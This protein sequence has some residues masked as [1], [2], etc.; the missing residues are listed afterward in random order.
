MALNLMYITNRPEVATIAQNSGVDRIFLDMEIIGKEAR[1]SGMDTVKSHHTVQ[2]VKAIRKVID[3]SELL[4]RVNPLHEA[5]EKVGS[6]VQEIEDTIEAGA[7]IIMLP[8]LKTACET[9]R[10]VR[11]ADGRVKTMLL[12]ETAEAN[13][14]IDEILRVEGVDEIHVGLNDLHLAYGKK[15]MFELLADGTVDRLCEKFS[16]K[17]LPYGF[18]GIARLGYGLLPAEKVIMEHYRL[19]STRAI[20]SRSFCNAEG[21][22]D[23]I[24]LRTLFDYEMARIRDF[25]NLV[26]LY[27]VETL[28][29]NQREVVRLVEKIARK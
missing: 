20:L 10:F 21:I 19:G 23:I 13:E 18:G 3:R 27:D 16:T 9:E 26:E 8:M 12:I 7:D 14:N 29:A 17:G 6:S 15:F 2:D 22:Q 4:V 11:I 1:Q 25:E 24:Q 5:D 28:K